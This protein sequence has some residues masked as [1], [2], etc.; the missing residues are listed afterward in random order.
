MVPC[1]SF[2]CDYPF[3]CKR[4]HPENSF[5]SVDHGIEFCE[6][7]VLFSCEYCTTTL[8]CS[9]KVVGEADE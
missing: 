3:Y 7:C 1:S 4:F 6:E 8:R 9:Y 2:V 5:V